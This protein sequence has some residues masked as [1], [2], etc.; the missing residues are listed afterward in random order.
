MDRELARRAHAILMKSLDVAPTDRTRFIAGACADDSALHA[1]VSDLVSALDRSDTFLEIPALES[2]RAPAVP[3]LRGAAPPPQIE[4]IGAYRVVRVIGAGGMATVYEAVQDR[5]QRRVALKVMRQGLEHTTAIDR[6]T[7]ECEVLARLAHPGIA[8]IFEAGTWTDGGGAVIPY[9]AMEYIDDARTITTYVREQRLPLAD[10]L[11]MLIAVCD[12]VQHGHQNGVIHRDLKPPNILVGADGRPRVIDFGV[13]RSTD[14]ALARITRSTDVGQ[15]I[16][17]LNYM[18]PEQC[19][20]RTPIDIRAD[21][22]ALGVILYELLCDRLPHDL[23]GLPLPAALRAIREDHPPRPGSLAPELSGDLD[24]IIT[25]AIEKEPARRYRTAAALAND[26][27]RFLNHQTIEARPLTLAYQCRLFARRNRGLV[28]ALSAI[29]ATV[30]LGAVLSAAFGIHALRESQRRLSAESQALAERD[31]AVWRSYVADMA[32]AFSALQAGE[33]LQVRS[34]LLRAAEEHRGWEWRF[35]AGC[36][37]RSL[38]RIRAH[39]DRVFS[40]AASADG[41]RLVTAGRD[42]CVR[43][44]DSDSLALLTRIEMPAG[45]PVYAAAFSPDG[46]QL[47]TGSEDGA[48]RVWSAK[49]GAALRTLGTHDAY[50]ERVAWGA[51]HQVASASVDGIGRIWNAESGALLRELSDQTGGVSG[52]AFSAD[53][54]MLLSWNR[55]GVACLRCGTDWLI[56]AQTRFDGVLETGVFSA[57]DGRVALG[58]A[59]GR[60]RL[61]N[62]ATDTIEG[63]ITTPASVSSVRALAFSP[64][65]QQLVAGQ[66]DRQIHLLAPQREECLETLRGH[67]EAVS[68]VCFSR[69]GRRI[70]SSSW[71]GT[72]RVWALDPESRTDAVR[73]LDEHDGQ[74]LGVAFAPGPGVLASASRDG[75]VRLWDA[76]TGVRIAVLRGH[77]LDVSSVTFSPDGALLASTSYD[78]TV[79]LWNVDTGQ[80]AGVLEGHDAE[81]WTAAFHPDG[82]RLASG[83]DDQTVHVWDIAERRAIHVLGGHSERVI[84]VAFSPDGRLLASASRDQS[85]RLWDA[86]RG[87]FIRALDGHGAD[88][89]AV[90]FSADGRQLYTGSRDQTVR[91]WNVETGECTAVLDGHGQFVTSLALS[92]DGTRLAAGSWFGQIV[93]WDLATR[94]IVASIAAQPDAIRSIAFSPDGRWLAAGSHN[95]TVRL[96]DGAPPEQRAAAYAAARADYR[97]AE[98]IVGALPGDALAD[99]QAR[100]ALGERGD[101]SPGVARWMRLLLVRQSLESEERGD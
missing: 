81:V 38:K 100:P 58:G 97:A 5:P 90:K 76:E 79:R 30:I 65:G 51:D 13:A 96:L 53:G 21:V 59:G 91:V 80:P 41:R 63:E 9:F 24:A 75:R 48:V 2:S 99:Q 89:F 55:A 8:Q 1:R 78:R 77:A 50:V 16:G 45:S 49:D 31:A 40:L 87:A 69:D 42:G 35:L 74:V 72:L 94:D 22:Y 86:E 6:F 18:S 44:W 37:E 70:Y 15:L 17:T 14:P 19:G 71:D 54:T 12:A 67:E 29:A 36:A 46:A 20:G 84:G 3:A 93:L 88:V 82:A 43:V 73:T 4:R 11:R 28:A 47:V 26:L 23:S 32:A 10:R 25:K 64:D 98:R 56:E 95:R 33:A 34:R 7:F 39:D 60:T 101:I 57:H 66:I 85:V 68:G 62:P 92:P 83:G 61:W 52:V 27:H